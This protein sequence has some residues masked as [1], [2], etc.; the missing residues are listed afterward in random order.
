MAWQNDVPAQKTLQLFWTAAARAALRTVPGDPFYRDIESAHGH[1]GHAAAVRGK[2][3]ASFYVATPPGYIDA[4]MYAARGSMESNFSLA[5]WAGAGANLLTMAG[6]AA[7]L[8][9]ATL[10]SSHGRGGSSAAA[11]A[12]A[13]RA[14]VVADMDIIAWATVNF[15]ARVTLATRNPAL[16]AASVRDVAEYSLC[17]AV[18]RWEALRGHGG[19]GGQLGT[20]LRAGITSDPDF[21]S[22]VNEIQAGM[23]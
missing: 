2:V 16:A 7:E 19:H 20:D 15:V 21:I 17:L 22:V 23:T 14:T 1:N 10:E 11:I 9:V 3:L 13:V 4:Q 5:L 6:R 18:Q 12:A 8:L